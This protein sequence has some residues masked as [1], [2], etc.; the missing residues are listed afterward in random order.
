MFVNLRRSSFILSNI[1]KLNI[2]KF[3]PQML[4]QRP[5]PSLKLYVFVLIFFTLLLQVFNIPQQKAKR[6]FRSLEV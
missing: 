4:F 2:G 1:G 6:L 3:T 5:H